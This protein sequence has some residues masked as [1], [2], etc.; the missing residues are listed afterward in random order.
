MRRLVP[1]SDP[2][3]KPRAQRSAAERSPG[4]DCERAPLCKTHGSRARRLR[5]LIT[6]DAV[7]GL[8]II[9]VLAAVLVLSLNRRQ[10]AGE[11]LS[12]TRG[13]AWAAEQALVQMQAGE[14]SVAV[15]GSSIAVEPLPDDPI[16]P[17]G[18]AWVRVR[19]ERNGRSAMLTALV[20]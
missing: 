4:S 15:E 14:T 19:S 7:M 8:G 10:R 17:A 3:H 13:A 5:G 12:D 20:P 16:V 11:R 2:Q 9:A 18:Y 6:P 1:H